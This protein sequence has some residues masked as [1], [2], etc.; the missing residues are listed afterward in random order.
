MKKNYKVKA[1]YCVFIVLLNLSYSNHLYAQENLKI[2]ENK[3]SIE[4]ILQ[5]A[6]K[7]EESGVFERK[8]RKTIL[9]LDKKYDW[10]TSLKAIAYEACY[11]EIKPWLIKTAFN[12]GHYGVLNGLKPSTVEYLTGTLTI[13][14]YGKVAYLKVGK[15]FEKMERAGVNPGNVYSFISTAIYEHYSEEAMESLA[16]IY[17]KNYKENYD[18]HTSLENALTASE[19]IRKIRYERELHKK[20]FEILGLPG[21]YK[22]NK[23]FFENHWSVLNIY[24]KKSKEFNLPDNEID[25]PKLN[26]FANKW[27]NTS[28]RPAG[29]SRKGI[30]DA[31]LIYFHF[32]D[33]YGDMKFPYSLDELIEFG[34]QIEIEK[35]KPG[36]IIFLRLSDKK[37]SMLHAGIYLDDGD[38]L[39]ANAKNGVLVS[40]INDAFYAKKIIKIIRYLD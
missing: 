17:L 33:Q 23:D 9:K 26:T 3:S 5:D 20:T 35:I 8:L 7:E 25:I 21:E 28:F 10:E 11:L 1:Y 38:F 19:N 27:K 4:I 30:D 31:G 15:L 12:L 32:Q 34:E 22:D 2:Q 13:Q 36:D 37:N 16:M 18:H 29:L 39:H 6:C 24:K 40:S 14:T